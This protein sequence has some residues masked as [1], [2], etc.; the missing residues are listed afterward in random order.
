M[1]FHIDLHEWDLQT[2]GQSRENQTFSDQ[3]F[4]KFSKVWG[5][6]STPSA[7]RSS[8]TN[9]SRI[10]TTSG[11]ENSLKIAIKPELVLFHPRFG[12]R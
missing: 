10:Y 8:A 1:S 6:A 2:Y 3:W 4:T 7:R 5:S 11:F 9:A 12:I